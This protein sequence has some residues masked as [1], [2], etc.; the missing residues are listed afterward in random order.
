MG[1]TIQRVEYFYTTVNDRP[2]EALR[3]L[4]ALADLGVNLVAFTAIPTGFHQTQLTIFPAEAS[5]LTSQSARAGFSVQGPH[6]ALLVQGEDVPGALVDIHE[7]LQDAGVN[8]YAATGVSGGQGSFGYVLHMR[9]S[10]FERA[11][12][13]LGV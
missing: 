9:A 2:G 8:V 3:F 4:T 13:V 11:A 7:R 10:D 12:E 1:H 6:S 5:R